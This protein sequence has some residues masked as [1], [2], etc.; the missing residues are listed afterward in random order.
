MERTMKLAVLV[1]LLTTVAI[2]VVSAKGLTTRIT[3][4]DAT[5]QS[6]EM[7]DQAVVAA[8]NVW[9]GPGTF[10]NGVEGTTGFIIDWA[11]GVARDR[12]DGLVRYEVS[13]IARFLGRPTEDLVYVVFYERDPSSGRGFVYLPGKSDT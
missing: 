9:S 12:P 11:A 13:F 1:A 2:T 5:H 10:T 6:I 4:K 3:L 7:T 8:F